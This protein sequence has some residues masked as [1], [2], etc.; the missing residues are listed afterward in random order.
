VAHPT[1]GLRESLAGA[2]IFARHDRPS[3]WVAA[4]SRLL[5]DPDHYRDRAD[6]GRRRAL[7]LAALSAGDLAVFEETIARCAP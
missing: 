4:V 6:A 3:E 5:D 1:P 2:G 7:E